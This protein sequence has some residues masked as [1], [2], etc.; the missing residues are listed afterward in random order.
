MRGGNFY[1]ID[2]RAYREAGEDGEKIAFLLTLF[3]QR[4][5]R[6]ANFESQWEESALLTWPEYSGSFFFGR[7]QAP[8]TKRAQ[9]RVDSYLSVATSRFAAIAEWLLTPS[10]MMWSKVVASDDDLMKDRAV[11]E[12]CAKVTKILWRERYKDT[13]NFQGSNTQNMQ[14]LGVFGNMGMFVDEIDDSLDPSERGIRYMA[15][16]VGEWYVETNAETDAGT[17]P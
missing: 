5:V 15:M 11:A 12:W 17:R 3:A 1:D 7:D 13:A 4:R 10:N 2:D 16:P 8:G 14:G 6:R 9:F